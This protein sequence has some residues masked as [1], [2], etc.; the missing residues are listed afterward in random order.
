MLRQFKSDPRNQTHSSFKGL[1]T[2]LNW[3]A[4]EA[5]AGRERDAGEARRESTNKQIAW[6]VIHSVHDTNTYTSLCSQR[7]LLLSIQNVCP[8][9]KQIACRSSLHARGLRPTSRDQ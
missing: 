8:I 2:E 1:P 9:H 5:V 3:H 7:M 6:Q 4:P